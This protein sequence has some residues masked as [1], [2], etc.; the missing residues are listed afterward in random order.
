MDPFRVAVQYYLFLL[1]LILL[2]A[3]IYKMVLVATG[4]NNQTSKHIN[5]VLALGLLLLAFVSITRIEAA[6]WML[7][8]SMPNSDSSTPII[9]MP[10][11]EKAQVENRYWL[12][13]LVP[14]PLRASCVSLDPRLCPPNDI[15]AEN[16]IYASVILVSLGTG[17][18]GI[19]AANIIA[20]LIRRIFASEP[21]EKNLS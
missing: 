10:P 6:F 18:F 14:P 5:R 11:A 12:W 21:Q 19:W 4:R 16:L 8:S 1:L 7:L 2:L 3:F 20:N 9:D 15:T 13:L 17:L